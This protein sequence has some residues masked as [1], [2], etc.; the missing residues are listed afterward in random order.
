MVYEGGYVAVYVRACHCIVTSL[1]EGYTA[2]HFAALNQHVGVLKC[3]L[4]VNC[5]NPNVLAQVLYFK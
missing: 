3:L 4:D 1:Q 2:L 5:P